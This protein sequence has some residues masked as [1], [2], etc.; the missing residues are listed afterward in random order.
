MRQ[1]GLTGSIGSGKSTVA[2]ILRELGLPVLDA[3]A[4]SREG[5][6]VLQK[7]ICAAFPEVCL[8]GKLDRQALGRRVFNDHEARKVLESILHPY[9]RKRFAEELEKLQAQNPAVVV[10]EIPLLFEGGWEERLEGVLVVATPDDLRL[11]RVMERSGLSEQEV[12]ERDATQMPQDQK[13]RRATWLIWNDGN[14]SDLRSEVE[15][16]WEEVK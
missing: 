9:V 5:A 11:K 12:K 6:L 13:I 10:L 15:R 1:I 16:W 2:K 14:L 4:Y 7:E 8:E 3:D